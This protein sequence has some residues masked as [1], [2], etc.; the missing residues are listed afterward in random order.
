MRTAPSF[1]PDKQPNRPSCYV[2]IP[3][4]LSRCSYCAFS[5]SL[6]DRETADAYLDALELEMRARPC[7]SRGHPPASVYLGG[8]TPSVLSSTQLDYL[9]AMLPEM[10]PGS[11]FTCE[12]NPDSVDSEKLSLLR[13]R[14]VNRLSFGVQTF[15]AAGLAL[16]ERRHD[17]AAAR[18]AVGLAAEMGFPFL[19]LDLIH[20]WPGQTPSMFARDLRQAIDLGVTHLSC[21]SLSIESGTGLGKRIAAGSV[22]VE[23]KEG[24]EFWDLAEAILGKSGFEHYETSNFAKPGRACRHNVE[25][26]K[27]GEYAGYGAS[28]HSHWRGRRFANAGDIHAYLDSLFQGGSAEVFSEQLPPEEKAREC[29]VFWLRLFA[30]INA[31]EFAVRTGFRF[32]D[33]YAGVLPELVEKGYVSIDSGQ[34]GER[35]R[36]PPE[37]QPVLDSILA[38]LL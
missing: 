17:A 31:E 9:L 23:E 15:D 26:W 19:S 34:A 7:F 8:G 36:V 11:E 28:A 14:G 27:G 21:Y 18:R 24:R 16:L 1:W 25:I 33:L 13:E 5:S 30:G 10:A 38:E 29:A 22:T 6:Y 2:H 20:A 4:C 12:L 35:F 3:F 32:R 37:Y